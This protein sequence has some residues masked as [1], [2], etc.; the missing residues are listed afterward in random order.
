MVGP[1][2]PGDLLELDDRAEDGLAAD[3]VLLDQRELLVGQ[4][5]RLVQDALGDGDLADVVEDRGQLEVAELLL[6]EAHLGGDLQREVGDPGRVVAGVLVL[7][8]DGR[9]QGLDRGQEQGPL[10][11]DEVG[12][13]HLEVP[14]DQGQLRLHLAHAELG[15]DAGLELGRVER[16]GDVVVGA[17]LDP[18]GQHL[19]PGPRGHQDDGDVLDGLVG[20]DRLGEGVA[21]HPGHHDVAQDEVGVLLAEEL[22]ALLGGGHELEVELVGEEHLHQLEDLGIVVDAEDQGVV[23]LGLL[24]PAALDVHLLE[25]DELEPAVVRDDVLDPGLLRVRQP[26][27]EPD[28]QVLG[29]A[30]EDL[31]V[32]MLLALE[33]LDDEPGAAAELALRADGP[34]VDE[35]DLPGQGQ[36]DPRAL[37]GPG[38]GPVDLGEAVEDRLEHVGRDADPRVLDGHGHGLVLV[39]DVDRDLAALVRELQGVGEQVEDDLLEL[40]RV[41][42]Q[43]DGVGGVLVIEPDLLLVGQGLD[44]GQEGRDELDEIDDL[45]LEPHLAL[46]ELVQVEEVVDELEQLVA[47]ALHRLEGVL[48]RRRQLAHPAFEDGLERGQHQRERR[49]ELVIDV[50]EELRLELVEALELDVG[51][52]ELGRR[53]LELDAAAELAA[54]EAVHEVDA[55]ASHDHEG[56]QEEEVGDDVRPDGLSRR[57]GSGRWG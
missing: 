12:R 23:D 55:P 28:G 16:L 1:D 2:D 21:V 31:L 56:G 57:A 35:D 22:E 51:F 5:A 8:V 37:L 25:I 46:L 41:E 3:G 42:G 4:L 13:P 24:D 26:P 19:G 34:L 27:S 11:V 20:L 18:L 43:I 52:L 10:L 49:P 6:A 53:L 48:E 45:H 15:P 47:V 50:G 14:V 40:V 32:E 7:G 54:S 30:V 9:D 29:P 36:P 44:R 33:H 17:G 38:L 39:L